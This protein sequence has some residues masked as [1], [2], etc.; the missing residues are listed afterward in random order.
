M[1]AVLMLV[2]ATVTFAH[3]NG[4][5]NQLQENQQQWV[6][7]K[8]HMMAGLNNTNLTEREH[9][10]N[11]IKHAHRD[12]VMQRLGQI[13]DAFKIKKMPG[14]PFGWKWFTDANLTNTTINGTN[15]TLV[16]KTI[17]TTRGGYSYQGT[18]SALVYAD[19]SKIRS[20]DY[21]LHMENDVN[22][23]GY[24]LGMQP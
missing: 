10:L 23:T 15:Y 6:Q 24:V 22:A 20:L 13:R 21:S 14:F 2:G 7:T 12:I 3:F 18:I 11:D 9:V 1:V 5:N 8:Q 17:N 4:P 16:T 19:T